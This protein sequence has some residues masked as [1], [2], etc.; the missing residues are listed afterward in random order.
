MT[1]GYATVQFFDYLKHLGHDAYAHR[2][3]VRRVRMTPA[4]FEKLLGLVTGGPSCACR[5]ARRSRRSAWLTPR[6]SCSP[7]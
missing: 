3:F 4:T 2:W 6:S 7:T 5:T 1:R